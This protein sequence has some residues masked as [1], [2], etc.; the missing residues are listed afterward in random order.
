MSYLIC[1]LKIIYIYILLAKT[2]QK[3]NILIIHSIYILVYFILNY[4]I[5]NNSDNTVELWTLIVCIEKRIKYTYFDFNI[6]NSIK[7]GCRDL[8]Q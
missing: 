1:I 5:F 8:I 6:V 3:T 7:M 4:V 2:G